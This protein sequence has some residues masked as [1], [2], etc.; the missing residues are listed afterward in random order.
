L[1]PEAPNVQTKTGWQCPQGH[2]W[3][4]TYDKIRGGTGCPYCAGSLPKTPDD[5]HALAEKRGFVWT[6]PEVA[7]I[8]TKTGW[9]C[10]QGHHWQANY[11]KIQSGTGCPFCARR[12]PTHSPGDGRASAR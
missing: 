10:P 6:G 5:Y 11:S 12:A 9:Q 2:Q 8:K 3:Q 4:A 7:N 1:G